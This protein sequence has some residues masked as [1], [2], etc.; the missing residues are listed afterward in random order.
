MKAAGF[1]YYLR[2]KRGFQQDVLA[3]KERRL[4]NNARRSFPCTK[5]GFFS[6]NIIAFY[7]DWISFVYK[8]QPSSE[9]LAPRGREWRRKSGGLHLTAKGS[10][11]RAGGKRL[12]LLVVISYNNGVVLVEE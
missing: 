3:R 4:R 6:R 1:H 5:P 9:A 10:K 12:H 2:V 8:I 7:L 11:N